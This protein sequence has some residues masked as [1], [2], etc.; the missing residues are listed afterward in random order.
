MSYI[1]GVGDEVTILVTILLAAVL[2]YLAWLSTSVPERPLVR[3]VILDRARFQEFLQ[4]F[5]Q[6]NSPRTAQTDMVGERT[7]PPE[8]TIT[9]ENVAVEHR[10]N[11]S[12]AAINSE[13][14][15]HLL[16][17]DLTEDNVS[18]GNCTET[19]QENITTA[20]VKNV[21]VQMDIRTSGDETAE[22]EPAILQAS[23]V[24]QTF[25]D[26]FLLSTRPDG[27][28]ESQ[29]SSVSESQALPQTSTDDEARC[30]SSSS[31]DSQTETSE[32]ASSDEQRR[33]SSEANRM[34]TE[35]TLPDG[36]IR[37]RLKY[38]D[39]RQRLVQAR[40]EDT[41]GQFKR[42]HFSV[43]LADNFSVRFIFRGQELREECSTLGAYH[44]EDNS[45][46]HCLL[47][48]ISQSE[49]AT[50]HTQPFN[51]DL[52]FLMFPLF[53]LILGLLWYWRIM[54]RSYFSAVSTLSLVGITFLFL[55]VL[56]ASWRHEER[57]ERED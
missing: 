14:T 17:A 9:T 4:R 8:Q 15:A 3:I 56:L 44:V 42:A 29:M 11:K 45:V 21:E 53:G 51:I 20:D 12:S 40:P 18:A 31:F 39:E 27:T 26:S 48:R 43:E 2:I 33:Q 41:I 38:L 25:L 34:D 49:Q 46:I 13:T 54:Y 10:D 28:G 24:T 50:T 6:R 55:A 32:M 19:H 23:E 30:S 47:S 35:E 52:G 5:V 57:L 16:P 7:V 22:G 37:I 36:H 1:E